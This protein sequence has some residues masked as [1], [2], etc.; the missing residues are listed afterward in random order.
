M[1]PVRACAHSVGTAFRRHVRT[2]RRMRARSC[3][4]GPALGDQLSII[5]AYNLFTSSFSSHP[6]H[7]HKGTVSK[8][9]FL[10][11]AKPAKAYASQPRNTKPWL[12]ALALLAANAPAIATAADVLAAGCVYPFSLHSYRLQTATLHDGMAPLTHRPSYDVI[13]AAPSSVLLISY[14]PSCFPAL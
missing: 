3:V 9:I 7:I 4:I 14:Q 12:T 13:P 1:S 11:P 10:N 2:Y 8:H 6:H 5:R